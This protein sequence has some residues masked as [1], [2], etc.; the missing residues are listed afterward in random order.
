MP[1]FSQIS[2]PAFFQLTGNRSCARS[3]PEVLVEFR[4]RPSANG[5]E[6]DFGIESRRH[7]QAGHGQPR[8]KVAHGHE[9]VLQHVGDGGPLGRVMLQEPGDQVLGQG[10][11]AGRDVVLVAL[12]AR[13]GVLQRLRLEGGLPHQQRVQDA[14]QRPN[15]DLEEEKEVT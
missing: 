12:D 3:G 14:T 8:R 2:Y 1:N 6:V 4:E 10:A 9:V 15:I 13:I 11:H 7:G 5:N